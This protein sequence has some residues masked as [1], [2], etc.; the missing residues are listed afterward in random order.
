MAQAAELFAAIEM[1]DVAALRGM[2]A[3]E[4]A[5]AG[6]HNAEGL[7]AV[8]FALYRMQRESVDAL[9]AAK[10]SLDIFAA[11]ARTLLDAGAEANAVARNAMQVQPLHSAAAG[12]H[13][14]VCALLLARGADVNARQHGG[15]TSLHAAAQP[16]DRV[17]TKSLL[18]AGA[19]AA[20]PNDAGETP[21]AIAAAS[22]HAELAA[23]LNA[24]P[25]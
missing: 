17:L 24:Q 3:V 4:P 21:A 1:G 19:D 11:A 13:H 8:L 23:L 14:A 5:L 12:R 9:L 2:L 22:G 18:A 7:P 6:A 10:P 20:L 16:G 25:G 15:W